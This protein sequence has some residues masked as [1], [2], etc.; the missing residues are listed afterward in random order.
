MVQIAE[1]LGIYDERLSVILGFI[2]LL[3]V[4][5][6]FCSCRVFISLVTRLGFKDPLQFKWYQAFH[7]YHVYYWPVFWTTFVLHVVTAL[8]HTELPE[9]GDPDAPGHLYILGSGVISFIALMALGFSCRTFG[10]VFHIFTGKSLPESRENS[11]F[12]RHHFLYWI[13][14][15]LTIAVHLIF[16]YQHIGFWPS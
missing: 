7:K 14:L 9:F 5:A 10:G 16:S 13:V 15:I 11:A 3:F 1:N 2:T 12:Y 8:L 6:F 4:F